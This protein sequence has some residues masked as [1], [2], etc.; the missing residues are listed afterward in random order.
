M[1]L[2]WS[3]VDLGAGTVTVTGT[4]DRKVRQR[5]DPKTN[6]SRRT[7]PLT[8]QAMGALQVHQV[9]Q[10]L[11]GTRGSDDLVF[12]SARGTALYDSNI[13]E[14]WHRVSANLGLPSMP[15]H[16]LR[17]SAATIM[18]AQGVPIEV[19]SRL[20]GHASIRITADIYGHVSPETNRQ[21]AEA[22]AKALR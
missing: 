8:A 19:V 20:F 3:D 10:D 15:W 1:A 22:M 18:L 12:T 5:T 4:L 2:R 13:R 14:H 17:H 9:R 16:N 11:E 7:V 6:K 21:A